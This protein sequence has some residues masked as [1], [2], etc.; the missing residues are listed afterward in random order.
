LR[1]F[2]ADFTLAQPQQRSTQQ[3]FAA[4][5]R[6]DRQGRLLAHF[7]ERTQTTEEYDGENL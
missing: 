4:L 2:A 6:I 5:P 7:R 3:L 1:L